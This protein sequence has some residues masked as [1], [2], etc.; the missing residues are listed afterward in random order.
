[1]R[2]VRALRDRRGQ[3]ELLVHVIRIFIIGFLVYLLSVQLG[4]FTA[5]E[6]PTRDVEAA[7]VTARLVAAVAPDGT[8]AGIVDPGRVTSKRLTDSYLEGFGAGNVWGA[9]VTLYETRAALEDGPPAF[10]AW[11]GPQS[12]A[13]DLLALAKAGVRGRGGGQYW[14]RLLPV[15]IERPGSAAPGWLLVEVVRRT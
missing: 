1:M 7:L 12:T 6:I 15:V 14:S 2:R 10:E 3:M 9:R 4:F 8:R 5:M 13:A 11:L